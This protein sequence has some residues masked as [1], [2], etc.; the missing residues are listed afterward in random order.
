MGPCMKNINGLMQRGLYGTV[1]EVYLQATAVSKCEAQVFH[2]ML[3]LH[4]LH[5]LVVAF[6]MQFKLLITK[7]LYSIQL[8]CL[9]ESPFSIVSDHLV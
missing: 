6:W 7:A 2:I 4:K 3:L 9:R 1:L 5:C 8:N